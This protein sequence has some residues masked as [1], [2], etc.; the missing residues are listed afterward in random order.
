[1]GEVTVT[2]S[3]MLLCCYVF[4]MFQWSDKLLKLDFQEMVMFL[5]HLPTLDWTHHELEMVLSRAFMWHTMFSS[6]PSHLAS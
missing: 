3:V 4:Y 6:C 5:Q 1:M 2:Y